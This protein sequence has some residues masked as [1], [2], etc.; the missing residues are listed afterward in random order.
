VYRKLAYN[1]HWRRSLVGLALTLLIPST[2]V[3]HKYLGL[4][5]VVAYAAAISLLLLGLFR[6]PATGLRM[7]TVLTPSQL[8]WLAG[9]TL[10]LLLVAFAIIYPIV[11]SGIVGGGSDG[12]DALNLA[13]R[14][15]LAGR[16]PY[17]PRTYLGN[18]I[19]PMPG[20]LLLAIPFVLLGNSAYQNF[21]W[22]LVFI[23]VMKSHWRDWR[24]ALFLFW[25]VLALS[26][27]V[28]HSLLIGSDYI[29]NSLYV[30]VLML[31]VVTVTSQPSWP[32]W[33]RILLAVLLGIGLSSRANFL[34]L[35]P[36]I[37]SAVG[38]QAGWRTAVQYTGITIMAYTA[39]T[40]P[41]YLYD[42]PAFSPLHTANKLGQF[43]AVLPDAGMIVP[44]LT[45]LVAA[46]LAIWQR[47]AS[48]LLK[49]STVVMA[50]PVLAGILLTII[51]RGELDFRFASF[52]LFF[53]F[54]GAAAFWQDV[55]R[56]E[57]D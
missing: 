54:F 24:L 35:L 13:T 10:G 45:M 5:G 29:A 49:T 42:P 43:A 33:S 50:L 47:D 40:L 53:L 17:Y 12:D 55:W 15:L 25:L 52:G 38:R 27:A 1:T 4:W 36:L 8:F 51:T 22:L 9:L 21:F 41:F 48:H 39:V 7:M 11:D 46:G 34:L 26:P 37:F 16:Y 20:A 44:A 3:L 56:L 19:S 23:V 28:L 18:P 30:L 32:A 6:Y 31:G 57:A 14:E 2:A